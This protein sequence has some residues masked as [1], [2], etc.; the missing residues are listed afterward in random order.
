MICL[1]IFLFVSFLA[2]HLQASLILVYV[3]FNHGN[4]SVMIFLTK[5]FSSKL[6]YWVSGTPVTLCIFFNSLRS[7]PDCWIF[8]HLLLLFG[9]FLQRVLEFT[10]FVLSCYLW[11]PS[12][13]EF[14]HCFLFVFA[15]WEWV[16][17]DQCLCP[18][19]TRELSL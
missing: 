4:F 11:S 14:C 7:F 18:L 17:L 16:F 10:D 1:G 9:G 3:L 8:F 5:I 2:G 19:T 6:L 15:D 13:V 12:V